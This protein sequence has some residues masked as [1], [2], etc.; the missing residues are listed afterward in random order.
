MG[1]EFR[2]VADGSFVETTSGLAARELK[3]R[4]DQLLGVNK[5]M[6]SPYAIT[7]MISQHGKQVRARRYRYVVRNDHF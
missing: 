7:A 3:R 4:Y 6:R 2:N 1:I 5:E